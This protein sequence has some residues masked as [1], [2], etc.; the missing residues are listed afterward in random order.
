MSKAKEAAYADKQKV[1]AVKAHSNQ[2][3]PLNDSAP[4]PKSASKPA[5]RKQSRGK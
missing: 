2:L 1:S 4:M 3:T 5:G